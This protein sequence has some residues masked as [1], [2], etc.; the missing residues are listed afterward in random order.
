MEHG[1]TTVV[2]ARPWWRM[3]VGGKFGEL[4]WSVRGRGFL[5]VGRNP[6]R[7]D[8][9]AVMPAGVAIL[10]EGRRVY[11]FPT[12]CRVPGGTLERAPGLPLGPVGQQRRHRRSPS[13]RCCLVRDASEC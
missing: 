12:P 6:C 7:L 11:L 13:W 8:T 1:E 4:L 10:P 9:D 2:I 5:E 3:L